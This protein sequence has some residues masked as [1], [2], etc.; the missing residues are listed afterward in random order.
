MTTLVC[1]GGNTIYTLVTYQWDGEDDSFDLTSLEGIEV[2]KNLETLH[3][4]VMVKGPVSLQP[5]R[6]LKKLRHLSLAYKS[7]TDYEAL[8]EI[9]TLESIGI[10]HV[11]NK[12]IA[13][14]V[15]ALKEKGVTIN[16]K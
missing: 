12:N 5:L 1:E 2:L 13:L 9:N 4:H 8:L 3:A 16:Y 14:I 15:A 11:D 6:Q 10:Q 7:F